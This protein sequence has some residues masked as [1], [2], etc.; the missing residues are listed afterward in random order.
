MFIACSL[1]VRKQQFRILWGSSPINL[2]GLWYSSGCEKIKKLTYDIRK[3]KE[4]LIE[5]VRHYKIKNH[6]ITPISFKDGFNGFVMW[7]RY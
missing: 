4:E 6:T 3:T 5:I 7:Y 1:N 2:L